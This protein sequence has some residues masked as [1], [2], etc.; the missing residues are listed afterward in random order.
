MVPFV[1][2]APLTV[3]VALEQMVCI[4]PAVAVGNW[5]TVIITE[6]QVVLL[7]VPL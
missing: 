1:A 2:L 3:A 4:P 6:S 5:S 7:Q